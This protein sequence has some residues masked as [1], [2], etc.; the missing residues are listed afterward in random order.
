[1]LE[2]V[3]TFKNVFEGEDCYLPNVEEDIKEE[4]IEDIQDDFDTPTI[5]V[6]EPFEPIKIPKFLKEVRVSL[7]KLSESEIST[8]I[9]I[10][11]KSKSNERNISPDIIVITSNTNPI[12]EQSPSVPSDNEV[13]NSRDVKCYACKKMFKKVFKI[14]PTNFNKALWT[15]CVECSIKR[16]TSGMSGAKTSPQESPHKCD[17]C[18]SSFKSESD[19]TIHVLGIHRRLIRQLSCCKEL[20]GNVFVCH[21]I[22]CHSNVSQV[23]KDRILKQFNLIPCLKC[24]DLFSRKEDLEQHELKVHSIDKQDTQVSKTHFSKEVRVSLQKLSESEI[25]KYTQRIKKENTDN[26]LKSSEGNSSKCNICG[27]FLASE[28]LLEMHKVIVHNKLND[29][30]ILKQIQGAHENGQYNCDVCAK[31]FSKKGNVRRHIQSAHENIQYN[32]DQC[33]KSFCDKVTL[34][35]HI[36]SVHE[37]VRY[38]CD[39]CK[40]SYVDRGSLD[41]HN[42]VVHKNIRYNCDK[43]DKIFTLKGTLNQHIK[44]AHENVRINCEKCEKSFSQ[45]TPLITVVLKRGLAACAA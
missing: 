27:L 24:N 10:I 6:S 26:H 23:E 8:Y 12:N 22:Q 45:K 28:K 43:C 18:R 25:L 16:T 29:S 40:I 14:L 39:T 36:K 9:Q 3:D 4:I 41:S 5:K 42:R 37:N 17:A 21:Y 35:R 44:S 30:N 13:A 19:L 33:E 38:N 31:S 2:F 7:P 11:T 32:C 1:M 20:L 34:N 15:M